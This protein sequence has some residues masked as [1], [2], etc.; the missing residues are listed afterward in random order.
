[1]VIQVWIGR[2]SLIILFSLKYCLIDLFIMLPY[3]FNCHLFPIVSCK[4]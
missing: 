3:L 1:M 2:S 4:V